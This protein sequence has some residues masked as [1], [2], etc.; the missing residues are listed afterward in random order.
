MAAAGLTSG[1]PSVERAYDRPMTS[2]AATRTKADRPHGVYKAPVP[3]GPSTTGART[4]DPRTPP[5]RGRVSTLPRPRAGTDAGSSRTGG[6]WLPRWAWDRGPPWSPVSSPRLYRELGPAR[7]PSWVSTRPL[8]HHVRV[9]PDGAQAGPYLVGS[10]SRG[11]VRKAWWG[12]PLPF[13]KGARCPA[14][15]RSLHPSSFRERRKR[16]QP[17][18]GQR[19]K[20]PRSQPGWAR[21]GPPLHAARRGEGRA[22]PPPG[23]R[24]LPCLL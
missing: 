20:R 11:P 5:S 1:L 13:S 7:V 10:E 6:L 12:G 4:Q 2:K 9:R 19:C 21:G 22:P 23:S 8:R 18:R 15:A 14:P 24:S 3:R 17:A 16:S